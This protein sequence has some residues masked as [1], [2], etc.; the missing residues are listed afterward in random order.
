[1]QGEDPAPSQAERLLRPLP[2]HCC[3]VTVTDAHPAGLGWLGAV[4]GHKVKALGVDAFGQ[5]GSIAE[6]YGT[7]GLDTAA[8]LRT[9]QAGSAGPLLPV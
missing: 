3:L 6:L 1:M 4:E 2:R 7:Y 9:V 5:S 8:I